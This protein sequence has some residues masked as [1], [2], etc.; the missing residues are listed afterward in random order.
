MRKTLTLCIVLI[1]SLYVMSIDIHADVG[2]KPTADILVIGIE[3]NFYFDVLIEVQEEIEPLTSLE[4]I[5]MIDYN[6][7]QNDYP[8]E[9]LNG[10]QDD[11]GFA[12][13]TLY[14]FAPASISKLDAEKNEFH[15]GY[16]NAPR[17][18]KIVI[19]L[20]DD[21]LIVS[22][23]VERQLF[24]SN[25]TY[26]L[27]G[28]DLSSN[29]FGVGDVKEN[30]PYNAYTLSLVVRVIITIAVE[31]FI[32]WLFKYRALK[33]YKLTG[34]I[35]LITQTLL[36]LGLVFG[37]YFWGSLFGLFA[38]LIVGEFLVFVAEMAVY[39][40]YLKE[41][42]HGRAVLYGFVANLITLILTIFTVALI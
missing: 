15:L 22:K 11:D 23:V 31:L 36:S 9:V 8:S 26:D 3:E 34:F 42:G 33:S 28:V 13:R 39:A 35:N 24:N 16:F 7:Y 10:Y 20:E 12:S 14:S 6:Y 1:L 18:F 32:L 41:K 17:V 37:Y 4:L 21:T 30:I 5:E 19:V 29:Q 27:T 38:V 25:M 40:I 2:P